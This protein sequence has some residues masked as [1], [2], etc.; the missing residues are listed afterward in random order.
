MRPLAV[1]L[2]LFLSILL[3][4]KIYGQP[5]FRLTIHPPQKSYAYVVN[6]TLLESEKTH[7]LLLPTMPFGGL[8]AHGEMGA[9]THFSYQG[10]GARATI[11]EIDGIHVNDAGQNTFDFATL[12]PDQLSRFAFTQTSFM[13]SPGGMLSLSMI[14]GAHDNPFFLN[15]ESGSFERHGIAAGGQKTLEQ[16]R[17]FLSMQHRHQG[18]AHAVHAQLK[19]VHRYRQTALN[20]GFIYALS[21]TLSLTTSLLHSNQQL[22]E[23][24]DPQN[25]TLKTNTHF[26]LGQALFTYTPTPEITHHLRMGGFVK[27]ETYFSSQ[28]QRLKDTSLQI[29]YAGHYTFNRHTIKWG[30]FNITQQRLFDKKY[31]LNTLR[32]YLQYEA[33][34]LTTGRVNASLTSHHQQKESPQFSGHLKAQYPVNTH[35]QLQTIIR[36][37]LRLPTL[38]DLHDTPYYKGNPKLKPERGTHFLLG[39]VLR[40]SPCHV[41]DVMAGHAHLKNM[42]YGSLISQNPRRYQQKNGQSYRALSLESRYTFTTP[43][44]MGT[45]AYTYT[46]PRSATTSL[47]QN[48]TPRHKFTANTSLFLGDKHR[49]LLNGLYMGQRSSYRGRKL[50]P[51]FLLNTM[52]EYALS[53]GLKA[54]AKVDN[55]FNSAY[56]IVAGYP[57]PGRGYFIGFRAR[58]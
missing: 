18:A 41:V 56:Q 27:N 14:P 30:L 33:P 23:L 10:L 57:M 34:L 46:R 40:L 7:T 26:S 15:A 5:P 37:S 39:V 1:S 12:S 25:A 2:L 48:G 17:L 4:Q 3:P 16:G 45:L 44:F 21:P 36:A 42:I 9:L 58:F 29:H 20:T 51:F 6:H 50:R 47:L 43:N 32:T 53:P 54:Y 31:H 19:D 28:T 8:Q 13:D 38:L 24:Y 22:N 49:L 35:I 11:V 55:L 52:W